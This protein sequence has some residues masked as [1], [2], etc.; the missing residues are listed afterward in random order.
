MTSQAKKTETPHQCS[1]LEPAVQAPAPVSFAQLL[2]QLWA[3][4]HDGAVVVR[5]A[6]GVPQY[7]EFLSTP[8]RVVLHSPKC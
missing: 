5:F 3:Q 4:R 1:S 2:E 8:P 6:G 7:V